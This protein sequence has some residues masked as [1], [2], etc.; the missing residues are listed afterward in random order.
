MTD[1]ELHLLCKQ[2]ANIHDFKLEMDLILDSGKFR[3]LVR[4]LSD[5][6]EK[7]HPS[8]PFDIL[9]FSNK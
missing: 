6:K 4:I 3:T 2:Y 9:T 5:F 8:Y 1:Y 7:V